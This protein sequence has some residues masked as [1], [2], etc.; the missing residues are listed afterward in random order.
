M[1]SEIGWSPKEV[2]LIVPHQVSR[3]QLEVFCEVMQ[4]PIE[5]C[6]VTADRL[7]NVGAANIPIALSFAREEGRLPPGRKV[8]LIGLG[9]GFVV[10]VVP[11][12]T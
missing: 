2:D 7:G 6:Q 11:M 10:G 12:V 1:Q 4:F 8:V 9:S 3:R 5:R